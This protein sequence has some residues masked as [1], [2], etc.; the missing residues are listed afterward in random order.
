[1][2][3]VHT[4]FLEHLGHDDRLRQLDAAL[5]VVAGVEAEQDRIVR[6]DGGATASTT[7]SAKRIRFS[8]VPP[9]SSVRLLENVDMNWLIR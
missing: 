6:A 8:S 4:G 3:R 9:Y 1:M 7:S 5:D 2:Q